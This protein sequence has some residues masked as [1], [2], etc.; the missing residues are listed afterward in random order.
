M[1]PALIQALQH[2]ACYPHSVQE[3]IKVIETQVSWLLLTGQFAYKVKKTL[4]FGFLDFSTLEK[5]QY[6]CEEELRLNQRLAPDIY[7]QV[8]KIC[9]CD[10]GYTLEPHDY[11]CEREAVEYA[12]QMT[13]FDAEK[14]LDKMLAEGVFEDYWA[15]QLARQVGNFHLQVPKVT[16]SSPW[17]E[18]DNIWQLVQ[19]NYTHCLAYCEDRSELARLEAL[20]NTAIDQYQ[21]LLPLLQERKTQ[22]FVRECHG[23]L[24]LANVTLYKD[25][26]RLF[27]CIEFN[28]QFRWI[29]TF[30]DF[31]FLLMDLE[32]NGRFDLANR[33]LNHYLSFTG[34][35]QGLTLL[36]FYK[37]F[38]SMIRAKVATLGPQANS[39][40]FNHYLSLTEGYQQTHSPRII[41]MHGLSGSGKS[42][43]SLKMIERSQV[44]RI[45]SKTE[46]KRLHKE[47]TKRGKQIELHSPEVNARLSQHLLSLTQLMISLGYSVIVDGTFLKQHFRQK[48]RD[49]AQQLDVPLRIISCL[50]D[51]KLMAARLHKP[52]DSHT[53]SEEQR[54]LRLQSQLQHA[55]PLTDEELNWADIVHSDSDS[56]VVNFLQRFARENRK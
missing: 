31:A 54:L 37:S 46:R 26:L 23:D 25:Q 21:Q 22:G 18:A 9:P 33:A 13:Q 30:C 55:Q 41:L 40:T 34:D 17:G 4:D 43:L 53:L 36:R 19:D 12:V 3:P 45:R 24:H 49:L 44:V 6:Y 8:M 15:D 11:A 29:D 35:Y 16:V 14:D 7:L 48:Y 50:C 5:R 38:R 56:E 27:D 42:Y 2:S 1:Y 52:Q 47:L 39:Q 10:G 28:L 20:H 32:A 51:E